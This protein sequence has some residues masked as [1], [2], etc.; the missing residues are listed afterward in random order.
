MK[1]CDC[2][3][4]K[5]MFYKYQMKALEF[6]FSAWNMWLRSYVGKRKAFQLRYALVKHEFDLRRVTNEERQE[7]RRKMHGTAGYNE[8]G[9]EFSKDNEPAWARHRRKERELAGLYEPEDSIVRPNNT[10]IIKDPPN[11]VLNVCIANYICSSESFRSM[12]LS[13]NFELCT[14]KCPFRGKSRY[15]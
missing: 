12:G 1:D 6:A 11:C 8:F 9:G 5:E 10:F 13:C 2:V 4:W 15:C 7:A 3:T 14:T